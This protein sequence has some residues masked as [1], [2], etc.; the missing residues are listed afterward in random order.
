MT[1]LCPSQRA[2]PTHYPPPPHPLPSSISPKRQS[3]PPADEADAAERGD[4]AEEAEARRVQH[5]RVD[6]AGEHAHARDEEAAR[7]AVLRRRLR[8]DQQGDG[9]DELVGGKGGFR[10]GGRSVILTLRV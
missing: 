9:V 3:E 7:R 4:G 1:L 5:E 10:S 2:R 8:R 6:A